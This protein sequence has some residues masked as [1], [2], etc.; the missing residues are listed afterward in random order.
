MATESTVIE[1]LIEQIEQR[2][3]ELTGQL[4]DPAVMADRNRYTELA[5]N[6]R[7]LSAAHALA[8]RAHS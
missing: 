6:H 1:R 4:A 5:R 7:E 3:D 8:E 2:Y